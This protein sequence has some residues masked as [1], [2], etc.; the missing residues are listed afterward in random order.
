MG[1]KNRAI[2]KKMFDISPICSDSIDSQIFK[3]MMFFDARS[4]FLASQFAWAAIGGRD[5]TPFSSRCK[6]L[7]DA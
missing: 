7:Q 3:L 1:D 4:F 2:V 6:F 5:V